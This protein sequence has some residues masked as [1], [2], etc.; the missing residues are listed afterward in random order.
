M[1]INNKNE[2]Y[3]VLDA[4]SE[5]YI[6]VALFNLKS[7][8]LK[9]IK[10]NTIIQ[11]YAE[12]CEGAGEQVKNVMIHTVCP[13]HINNVKDFVDLST[14]NERMI[15]RTS[16]S[17]IFEGKYHGWC[18]AKFI[19]LERNEAGDLQQ[20]IFTVECIDEEKRRADSLLYLSQTDLMT[21]IK[22]RGYGEELIRKA[23]DEGVEGVFGLFD[24]D[25]FKHVNDLYGHR[26][27]DIVVKEIA[28]SMQRT[29]GEN[30]IFLRLGGDE[31]AFYLPG[32]TD[33]HGAENVADK[34][35]D[36]IDKIHVEPMKE[37]IAISLGMSFYEPGITFDTIYRR[38]DNGVYCSKR[39]KECSMTFC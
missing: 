3:M 1:N 19:V 17:H 14:L 13:E 2:Y 24:I 9:G 39:N 23:L 21:G 31:F 11:K 35:F 32:V 30:D 18:K 37:R 36:N 10:L 25:R 15:D 20:V 7:N 8:A 22:N 6:A 27:G 5:T 38:A 33:R 4:L 16:I 28:K 26:I 34:L 12:C 29:F